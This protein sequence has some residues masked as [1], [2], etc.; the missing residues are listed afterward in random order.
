MELA[1]GVSRL[2]GHMT[3]SSVPDRLSPR[4]GI[5]G[6]VI[7]LAL[8]LAACSAGA[9]PEA[10][11]PPAGSGGPVA[12]PGSSG[13]L[14]AGQL[15]VAVMQ[16]L[17]PRW[18]CD[19]D[20]YPL[21]RSD[22]Q[23]LAIERFPEMRAEGDVFGAVVVDL[24]LAGSATFTD[25]QKLAV[26]RLWKAASSF[27]F[28]SIGGGRFRFD[29]SAQPVAGASEGLRTT[30]TIDGHGTIAIETQTAT[31]QP[32]CPICLARGT[33]IDTPAGS[34]AVED[35]ALGAPVWTMDVD[36]RRIAGVVIAVGSTV[37]PAD[38]HVLRLTLADGRTVTAS[39]GHPLADGRRL[40]D[41]H[42]GDL[43]DGSVAIELESLPYTGG[44]TF[45]LVASGPTGVYFSDGIALGTTLR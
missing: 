7:V 10:S 33:P 16:R 34:V 32:N 29:Y 13:T 35:L 1:P 39:P 6:L 5:A 45:D 41:L 36:G 9:S 19:P 24:G 4:A 31:A 23:Q 14:T 40:G 42:V 15:R 21:A 20:F 25:A 17:G 3:R 18:W 8:A 38:H 37:A 30:G 26:Y 44:E 28:D 22:E 27:P 43:V 11:G 2:A 12:S